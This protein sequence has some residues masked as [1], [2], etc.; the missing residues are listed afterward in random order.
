MTDTKG[1]LQSKTF[2]GLGLSLVGLI[3]QQFG[4]DA[5]SLIGSEDLI[6]QVAGLAVA[7]YGRIKAV[8]KVRG[9]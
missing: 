6:L 7:G 3:M 4:Y 9:L 2:F 8:K 1:I 5:T